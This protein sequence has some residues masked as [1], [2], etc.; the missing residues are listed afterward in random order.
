MVY[1]ADLDWCP[2][3]VVEARVAGLHVIYEPKCKAV[4]ELCELDVKELY[5]HNI[6]KQY[7][8]VFKKVL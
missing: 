3:A 5:I 8:K 2:N 6:A 4:K 1:L 7:K